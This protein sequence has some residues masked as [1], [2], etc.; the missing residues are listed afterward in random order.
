MTTHKLKTWTPFYEDVV[1]GRKRFELRLNDRGFQVGDVLVLQEWDQYRERLTDRS[2]KVKE[3]YLIDAKAFG[4]L[5]E[6]WVCMSIDVLPSD[7]FPYD[8][9]RP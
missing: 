1:A 9:L 8:E 2:V 4:A 7:G 3:T 6:G 5:T